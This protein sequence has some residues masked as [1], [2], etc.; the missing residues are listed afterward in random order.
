MVFNV[1][2]KVRLADGDG[3]EHIIKELPVTLT[4][5]GWFC[6]ARFEDGGAGIVDSSGFTDMIKI[7]NK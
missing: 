7:E 6:I 3:R 5:R 2:D 1:G 4:A